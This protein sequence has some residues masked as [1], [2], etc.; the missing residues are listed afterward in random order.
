MKV[1]MNDTGAV[2]KVNDSYGLR[3]IDRGMPCEYRA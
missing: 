2:A 1:R 3:L